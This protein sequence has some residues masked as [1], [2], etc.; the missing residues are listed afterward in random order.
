MDNTRFKVIYSQD[1][2]VY[3]ICILE[4]TLTGKQYLMISKGSYTSI[5]PL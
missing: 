2:Q 5:C 3:M 1:N 4:D